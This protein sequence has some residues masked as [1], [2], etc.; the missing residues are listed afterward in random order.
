MHN[1]IIILDK[2]IMK[3]ISYKKNLLKISAKRINFL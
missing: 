2:S 3:I 1:L